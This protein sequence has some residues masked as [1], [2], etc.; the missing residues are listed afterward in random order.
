MWCCKADSSEKFDSQNEH[1]TRT[2]KLGTLRTSGNK[3][4]CVVEDE[5]KISMEFSLLYIISSG[6]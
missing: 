3:G 2:L 5:S 6:F 1:F 4:G